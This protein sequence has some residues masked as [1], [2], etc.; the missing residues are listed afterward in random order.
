MPRPYVR[1]LNVDEVASHPWAIDDFAQASNRHLSLD[2]ESGASTSM[3]EMPAGW[4]APAG[5]FDA[6]VELLVIEGMLRIG[7]FSLSST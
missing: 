5:T 3:L 7:E 6:G 2:P 4:S 1:M